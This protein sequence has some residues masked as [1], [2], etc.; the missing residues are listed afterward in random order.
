MLSDGTCVEVHRSSLRE[1]LQATV[2]GMKDVLQAANQQAF[3]GNVADFVASLSAA[4]TRPAVNDADHAQYDVIYVLHRDVWLRFVKAN[5]ASTGYEST[6]EGVRQRLY[7]HRPFI[8]A[9]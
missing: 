4:T 2:D 1:S 5:M 3:N 9:C 8:K 6:L 7:E